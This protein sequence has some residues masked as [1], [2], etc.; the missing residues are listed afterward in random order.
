MTRFILQCDQH[1]MMDAEPNTLRL[2]MDAENEWNAA[3][4]P[5]IQMKAKRISI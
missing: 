4:S 5:H 2:I 3:G 1:N